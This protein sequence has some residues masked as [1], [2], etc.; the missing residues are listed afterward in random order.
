MAATVLSVAFATSSGGTV[1]VPTGAQ[2]VVAFVSGYG[3]TA[4]STLST[5]S[6]GGAGTFNVVH[7]VAAETNY[8]GSYT[9]ALATAVIT[10]TGTQTLSFAFTNGSPNLATLVF[11][12]GID[13]ADWVRE[14]LV[15]QATD[16]YQSAV[17]TQSI[18]STTTDLVVALQ[19]RYD[20]TPGLPS[21]WTSISTRATGTSRA[22]V[23]YDAT[24][25]ASTTSFVPNATSPDS[26]CVG[27][28]S[29][30]SAAVV[31]WVQNPNARNF[32]PH[33]AQ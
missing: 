28:I 13:T 31:A 10:T 7:N 18:S 21:G 6:L 23:S 8:I 26:D 17:A 25:G 3:N 12:D 19:S 32:R 16:G 33:M 4:G 15:A 14:T 5:I 30:K 1:T 24:P 27:V 9:N 20:V 2:G 11:V 22:R 29:I